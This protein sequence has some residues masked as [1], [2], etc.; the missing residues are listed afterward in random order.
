MARGTTLCSRSSPFRTLRTRCAEPRRRDP[1]LRAPSSG[2]SRAG[3]ARVC[4]TPPQHGRATMAEYRERTESPSGTLDGRERGL[5]PAARRLLGIVA[6]Y[7][8]AGV[9]VFLLWRA[10]PQVRQI[11]ESA[12]LYEL[13]QGD[14]FSRSRATEAVASATAESGLRPGTLTLFA[15]TGALLTSLPVAWVYSLTRRK[16]GFDQSMVHT[17]ILLPLAVAGMV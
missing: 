5:S 8:V 4:E 10:F 14:V 15:L 13:T 11:L 17:V 6:Y 7:A 16:K 3:A 12:R 2:G 1:R 9:G